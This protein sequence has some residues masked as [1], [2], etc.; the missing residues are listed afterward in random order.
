MYKRNQVDAAV[1]EATGRAVAR[2]HAPRPDLAIRL[3]RLIETDRAL[4]G[5]YAFFEQEG[6][7]KGVEIGYSPYAVFALYLAVRLMD[8]G[9]PQA[10]AVRFMRAIRPGLERA[11][12]TILRKEPAH[13]LDHEA[14]H[15]LERE[16]RLGFLVRHAQ[17]MVFLAVQADLDPKPTLVRPRPSEPW[18]PANICQ[19]PAELTGLL[20]KLSVCGGPILVIEL[21][22]VIHRLAYWLKTIEPVKRGRK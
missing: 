3:K 13:W 14:P 6:E 1:A 8:A 18:R 22:N 15:G 5:K 4:P 10:D 19:S 7:G 9:L 20:A 17:N 16:V 11:H 21:V 12:G 2:T